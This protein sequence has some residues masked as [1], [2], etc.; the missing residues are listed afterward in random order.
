ME[1]RVGVVKGVSKGEGT[2][3]KVVE[4]ISRSSW[5]GVGMEETSK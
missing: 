1:D 3:G 5:I 4:G 2:S